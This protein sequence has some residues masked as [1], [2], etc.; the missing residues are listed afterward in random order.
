M[1]T[2][3]L[4][5]HSRMIMRPSITKSRNAFQ[6]I[7]IKASNLL[8]CNP[9]LANRSIL[10][11]CSNYSVAFSGVIV[12]KSIF[13]RNFLLQIPPSIPLQVFIHWVMLLPT[14]IQLITNL[15]TNICYALRR[16]VTSK[17]LVQRSYLNQLKEPGGEQALRRMK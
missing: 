2:H 12:M 7:A 5:G 14:L 16:N 11:G 4:S 10:T 6:R 17:K 9:G 8:K 13:A 1:R 15:M 3:Y